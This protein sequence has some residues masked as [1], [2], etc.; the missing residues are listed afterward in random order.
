MQIK[1]LTT[2]EIIRYYK[3]LRHSARL[4]FTQYLRH[5][6]RLKRPRP[7]NALALAAHA[8]V[9]LGSAYKN[10]KL[11]EQAGVVVPHR[12]IGGGD[13]RGITYSIHPDWSPNSPTPHW[14]EVVEY[15]ADMHYE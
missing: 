13:R 9:T 15:L 14:E 5:N 3:I 4:C 12:H 11:L 7:A 1:P 8:G 6:E 2:D 10:L